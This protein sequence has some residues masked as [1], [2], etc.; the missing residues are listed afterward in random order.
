MLLNL[1][2]QLVSSNSRGLI[3]DLSLDTHDSISCQEC[4]AILVEIVGIGMILM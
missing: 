3:H 1:V 4:I 2:L